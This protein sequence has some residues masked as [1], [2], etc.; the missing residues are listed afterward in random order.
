M[1]KLEAARDAFNVPDLS[2]FVYSLSPVT[3]FYVGSLIGKC[4]YVVDIANDMKQ[5]QTVHK[6][7]QSVCFHGKLYVV[8]LPDVH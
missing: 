6:G 4:S 5:D 3:F 8:H 1:C 2:L 7:I